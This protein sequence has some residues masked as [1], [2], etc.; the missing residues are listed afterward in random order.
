MGVKRVS[1]FAFLM[2]FLFLQAACLAG[3]PKVLLKT[4]FGDI[5]MELYDAN[6]P[7]TV[8]NFLQYV[9]TGFYNDLIFHRV[10]F[11]PNHFSIIQGGGYYL[12]GHVI[13]RQ[14]KL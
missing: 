7:I 4:N 1:V 9:R 12:D 5:T 3:Y 10:V 11:D 2:A 8:E 14:R 13:Y 6:A